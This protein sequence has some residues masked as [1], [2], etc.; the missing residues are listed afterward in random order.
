MTSAQRS[1]DPREANSETAT[2]IGPSKQEE[3][4]ERPFAQGKLTPG[5]AAQSPLGKSVAPTSRYAQLGSIENGKLNGVP[6]EVFSLRVEG[7]PAKVID[8]YRRNWGYRGYSTQ[9]EADDSRGELVGVRKNSGKILRVAANRIEGPKPATDVNFTAYG[10]DRH[11]GAFYP[12]RLPDP[13]WADGL[14]VTES[15]EKNLK[16]THVIWA[17][18]RSIRKVKF[19]VFKEMHDK[20]WKPY[21]GMPDALPEI[22]DLQFYDERGGECS[23]LIRPGVKAGTAVVEMTAMWPH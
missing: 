11:V 22:E 20:G 7:E 19:H 1:D 16:L 9:G 18:A 13:L 21:L 15:V 3:I 12:D 5:L 10:P 4:L 8:T 2:E 14:R 17:S 23:I 6:Y